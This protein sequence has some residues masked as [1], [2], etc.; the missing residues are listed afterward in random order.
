MFSGARPPY[1]PE[2]LDRG[3]PGLARAGVRLVRCPVTS[4]IQAQLLVLPT[5]S[6]AGAGRRSAMAG[7]R[8][9][10]GLVDARGHG[11]GAGLDCEISGA[12]GPKPA[13]ARDGRALISEGPCAR[14]ACGRIG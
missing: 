2:V 5:V 9:P 7:E 12:T 10:P 14:P 8:I 3:Q 4:S 13:E 11:A 1:I 6:S